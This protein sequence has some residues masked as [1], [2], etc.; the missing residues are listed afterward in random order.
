MKE[1]GIN[2]KKKRVKVLGKKL[3][4]DSEMTWGQRKVLNRLWD[5][6]EK[7]NVPPD[8]KDEDALN[9][10]LRDQ[11]EKLIE[12]FHNIIVLRCP[13]AEDLLD[14]LTYDELRDLYHEV[15][16][17]VDEPIPEIEKE[18]DKDT[19]PLEGKK[20]GKKISSKEE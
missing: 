18:D 14:A 3:E 15:M 6:Y 16:Y 10:F 17:P 12:V 1:I 7:S 11:E 2:R 19:T 13:D 5:E 4:W 9:R 8:S 20:R